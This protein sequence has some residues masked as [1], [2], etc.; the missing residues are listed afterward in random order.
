M[1]VFGEN[2]YSS[3]H[4]DGIEFFYMRG[5]ISLP[6]VGG[7]IFLGSFIEELVGFFAALEE[8]TNIFSGVRGCSHPRH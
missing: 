1:T 5:D 7:H 8:T 4:L 2:L 6:S 3:V